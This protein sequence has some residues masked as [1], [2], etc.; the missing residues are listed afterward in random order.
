MPGSTPASAASVPFR[1]NQD[2]S[3]DGVSSD[4]HLRAQPSPLQDDMAH[5][6]QYASL[7]EAVSN[8]HMS[9]RPS[10]VEYMS[11]VEDDLP[12]N[13]T[14]I[15]SDHQGDI[16]DLQHVLVHHQQEYEQNMLQ[17]R[18][19][20]HMNNSQRTTST[21]AP[22]SSHRLLDNEASSNLRDQPSAVGVYDTHSL[23]QPRSPA[24]AAVGEQPPSPPSPQ[25]T[26]LFGTFDNRPTI[27]SSYFPSSMESTI[28]LS[29]PP[30]GRPYSRYAGHNSGTHHSQSPNQPH[31]ISRATSFSPLSQYQNPSTFSAV[32][33]SPSPVSSTSGGSYSQAISSQFGN[34]PYRP[35]FTGRDLTEAP[36]QQNAG[37]TTPLSARQSMNTSTASTSTIQI[38]GSSQQEELSE[39]T[40]SDGGRILSGNHGTGRWFAF[41]SLIPLGVSTPYLA[42]WSEAI[43]FQRQRLRHF[44]RLHLHS[45]QLQQQEGL[46]EP[47]TERD[48]DGNINDVVQ[49]VPE[50]NRYE[51]DN[52]DEKSGADMDLDDPSDAQLERQ[53]HRRNSASLEADILGHLPPPM[54]SLP[55]IL[56][57]SSPTLY[58]PFTRPLREP[59]WGRN[60]AQRGL[61]SRNTPHASHL[62]IASR[63]LH[64]PAAS[65]DTGRSVIDQGETVLSSSETTRTHTRH[66]TAQQSASGASITGSVEGEEE[67][68]GVGNRRYSSSYSITVDLTT[69]GYHRYRNNSRGNHYGGTETPVPTVY[70]VPVAPATPS[71]T[72]TT[73]SVGSQTNSSHYLYPS[74]QSPSLP[75]SMGSQQ[76]YRYYPPANRVHYSRGEDYQSSQQRQIG[77]KEVVRMACRFCEVLLCE[78]GMK[79]QLLADQTIGLFSTDDEPIT[80]LESQFF[81]DIGNSDCLSA[82]NNGHLWLFHPE[83]IHCSPRFDPVFARPLR[84]QDLPPPD[85]DDA[86]KSLGRG[87]QRADRKGRLIMGGMVRRDY[88]SICR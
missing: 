27:S 88:D 9:A 64:R 5:D 48:F 76:G 70:S 69:S 68:H 78:R 12:A 58:S 50:L 56:S 62:P 54:T 20:Y 41:G 82:E 38:Q 43:H 75:S 26:L 57:T 52:E 37:N 13:P 30:P 19:D 85:Q 63:Y 31:L 87:I 22:S 51:E 67:S 17:A 35:Y 61:E 14:G 25:S 42:E 7:L 73:T 28:V 59:A 33:S 36:A 29:S 79:A 34:G 1:D 11:S 10:D 40:D 47:T 16:Y 65:F 81:M 3:V 39:E 24:L 55:E 4:R 60:S 44:Q 46:Q 32:S 21:H 18:Q 83:Y 66:R 23:E 84:W 77:L 2:P 80:F 49:G 6:H 74:S 53:H 86:S 71:T 72:T 8:I 45:Q 15:R